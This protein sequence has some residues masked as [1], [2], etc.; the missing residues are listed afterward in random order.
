LAELKILVTTPLKDP[1][2]YGTLGYFAG[3]VAQDKVPVFNGIPSNISW[4]ALKHL[5]AAAATSGSVAL[6]H[7]VGV[8]PEAPT[9]EVAFGQKKIKDWQTFEFGEK[10]LRETEASLSKA[11]PEEVDLV[12][13]GCPHASITEFREIAH[14]LSGRR[15]KSGVEVWI[16]TSRMVKTYAEIM[17]YTNIIESA[18][19]QILCGTCPVWMFEPLASDLRPR[20][21]C[22]NSAKLT[23]AL[24]LYRAKG[25]AIEVYYGSMGRCIEAATHKA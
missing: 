1:Y 21:I 22:T 2:D 20:V 23:Y 19:A 13:L 14:A 7:V 17:G 25:Q 8:T 12:L 10:E 15:L 6:Y 3:R 24:G 16:S 18:G 5:G 9:E 11:T 4:D